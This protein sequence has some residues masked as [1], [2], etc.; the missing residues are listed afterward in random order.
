MF[1]A[2]RKAAADCSSQSVRA[3]VEVGRSR[4]Q[5]GDWLSGGK[6][7]SSGTG[8]EK[9]HA[10]ESPG[11]VL[12]VY[13]HRHSKHRHKEKKKD[14]EEKQK[15]LAATSRKS[16]HLSKHKKKS[17]DKKRKRSRS[18]SDSSGDDRDY[19]SSHRSPRRRRRS[20]SN[21]RSRARSQSPR[22]KEGKRIITDTTKEIALR[23][24]VAADGEG[25][26]F[27]FD[28]VGDRNNQFF[29][30]TYVHDRPLYELATRRNFL[31]VGSRVVSWVKD[32][33]T[34]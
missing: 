3:G 7:F 14:R 29:G 6:S 8:D 23:E 15:S 31:T 11:S 17:K 21:P 19:H 5:D 10:T 20:R 33:I 1:A 12:Q 22:H 30:S 9:A 13:K 18:R 24:G 25:K 27:E 28:C 34:A 16:R 32:A 2:G 4:Q 26:I